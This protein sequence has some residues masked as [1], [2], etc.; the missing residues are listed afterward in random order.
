MFQKLNGLDSLSRMRQ[1]TSYI[2]SLFHS[3]AGRSPLVTV[4]HVVKKLGTGVLIPALGQQ[5]ASHVIAVSA[6]FACRD[7][8]LTPAL[9][10]F[11]VRD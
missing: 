4:G 8:Y 10:R 3:F 7:H 11:T 2:V 9:T 1:A 6:I 5:I